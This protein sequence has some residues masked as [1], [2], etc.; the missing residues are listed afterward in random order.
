MLKYELIEINDNNF[1]KILKCGT[2]ELTERN[3]QKTVICIIPG[4][5]YFKLINTHSALNFIFKGNPGIVE[6]YEEFAIE[7]NKSTGLDVIGV[8][9][10]G[11]LYDQNLNYWKPL[12]LAGQINDKLKY[13]NEHVLNSSSNGNNP[14]N[15]I[16][17]GHSIGCYVILQILS[18]LKKDQKNLVK[19]AILL[20]PTIE[21][22]SETPNGKIVTFFT[23]FFLWLIYLVAYLITF[24]PEGV[25]KHFVHKMFTEK[26]DDLCNNISEVV[27]KMSISFHCVRS[28]F[29]MGKHEM[30]HVKK[31]NSNLVEQNLDL[32]VLYY[33]M[34][35]QWCPL[36]YYYD[37]QNYVTSLV[38]DTSDE[39]KSMVPTLVLDKH[40]LEH[41]FVIYKRQCS[42]VANMVTEWV[43]LI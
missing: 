35:D 28:C 37:M 32:L 21:R 7:L 42:I 26:H 36:E 43:K 11:H 9:H 8:S 18:M 2:N 6:F 1:I 15:V 13:L 40:G 33:G 23:N 31:L 24:L 4:R 14:V 38:D 19:K 25:Q 27:H 29:Y 34:K 3:E 41:A 30:N 10:T 12:D 17:I 5:N 20:F 16:F 39:K 22:M